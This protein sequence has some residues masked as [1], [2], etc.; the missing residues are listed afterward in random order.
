MCATA[1]HSVK[2]ISPLLTPKM[3][4]HPAWHSWVKL[5]ELWS[6]VLKHELTVADVERIDDLQYEHAVLFASVPQYAGM[7]RPK[8][9]F[10][11]HLARDIWNYG[12]PRG[13]WTFGYESFNK[14][15]KAGAQRSNFKNETLSIMEYWSMRSGHAMR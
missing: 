5:V 8:H 14:V 15:I 7:K 13:Y 9:H 1:V 11:T 4:D 12:P 10:L 6:L 2:V 3:R